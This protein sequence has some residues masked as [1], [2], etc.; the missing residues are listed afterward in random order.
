A[1]PAYGGGPPRTTDDDRT[2]PHCGSVASSP[3]PSVRPLQR[4]RLGLSSAHPQK[5]AAPRAASLALL[6]G[7]LPF[8]SAYFCRLEPA[9]LGGVG[10]NGAGWEERIQRSPQASHFFPR[11]SRQG[12]PTS[13]WVP[14]RLSRRRDYP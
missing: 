10:G 1:P 3:F 12:D 13:G 9:C 8:L 7:F 5:D 2:F 11:P 6:S 14:S 4:S